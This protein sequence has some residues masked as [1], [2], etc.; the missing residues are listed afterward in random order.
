MSNVLSVTKQEQIQ[1]LIRLGWS[2]R[3]ISRE[4][5]VHRST[6]LRYKAVAQSVPEVPAEESSKEPLKEEEEGIAASPPTTKSPEL[7]GHE[8]T[9]L[10]SLEK[11]LTAQRIYQDLVEQGNYHGSYYS[12]KRY[13]RKVRK[14]IHRFTERLPHLPG[15]EVQVDFGL[16][17]CK[18][19]RGKSYRRVWLFKMTLACSKHSYEEL[20]ERQD[21]ATFIQCHINAFAFFGGTPEIV[22]LD[23]L[24]SGVLQA[25]LYEPELNPVYRAFCN[26]YGIVA[27]PCKPYTPEHKGVV[28]RDIQYTNSNAL[29]GRDFEDLEKANLFLKH[30]NKKW[31]RT[32]IH[33]STRKQVWS[34][35]EDVEESTLRELPTLPFEIFEY[36]IRKVD[37]NGCIEVKRNHYGVPARFIGESVIIHCSSTKVN[38]YKEEKFLISHSRLHGEGKVHLPAECLPPWKHPKRENQEQ[39]Y[40]VEAGRIGPNTKEVVSKILSLQDVMSIRRVRG[41]LSLAKKYSHPEMETATANAMATHD[42]RYHFIKAC[43]ENN[44]KKVVLEPAS[45]VLTQKHEAIRPLSEYGAIV[46]ERSL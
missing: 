26:H 23:N 45:H 30:W 18:V 13:V 44:S 19:K 39:Y 38:I 8:Q 35:F 20:V 14:K 41:I 16:S 28:E 32:R 46:N 25:S 22:T 27:N 12:V 42:Y 40:C 4:I 34:Y 6:I 37:V 10:D 31:A 24:K 1:S 43:C 15:R 7:A 33:G 2:D 5:G 21:V 11:G 36:G 29:D 9:I 3:S 17:R